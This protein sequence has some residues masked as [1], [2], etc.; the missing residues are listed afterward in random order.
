MPIELILFGI[1]VIGWLAL[2]VGATVLVL[3][4]DLFS[5]SQKSRQIVL[6]WL[7]PILGGLLAMYFCRDIKKSEGPSYVN[8]NRRE[9]SQYYGP[10]GGKRF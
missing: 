2:N 3:R 9:D 6:V 1:P 8:D 7:V 5:K 10:L 4:S